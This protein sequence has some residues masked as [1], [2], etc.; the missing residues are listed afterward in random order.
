MVPNNVREIMVVLVALLG[1]MP[2]VLFLRAHGLLLGASRLQLHTIEKSRCVYLKLFP[3]EERHDWMQFVSV[4]EEEGVCAVTPVHRDVEVLEFFV[5]LRARAEEERIDTEARKQ[6]D[7]D[8]TSYLSLELCANG[9]VSTLLT[10]EA[11]TEMEEA[12]VSSL[13]GAKVRVRKWWETIGAMASGRWSGEEEDEWMMNEAADSR[14]WWPMSIDEKV[15]E[16]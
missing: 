15:M 11:W 14:R 10:P 13:V 9:G 16:Q 5:W 3:E 1:C 7:A 4:A 6:M 8:I 2:G 12:F